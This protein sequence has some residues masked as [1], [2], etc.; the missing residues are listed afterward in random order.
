MK[1]VFLMLAG[2]FASTAHFYVVW[3]HRSDRRYSI[4]E[5]AMLSK[6]S[7]LIY[8]VTHVICEIFFLLFSYQ[9]FVREHQYWLPFYL[10]VA[11]A[12]LDFVQAALPSRGASE[13]V[14]FAAAYASWCCY[15]LAG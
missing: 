11:F 13:K 2:L 3:H 6:S 8:F 15:L 9:F 10:N 14:H 5:H 7:H 12:G 1:Y 4:S